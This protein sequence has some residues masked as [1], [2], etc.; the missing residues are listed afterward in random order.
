[1]FRINIKAF[2]A[3]F[4]L[5]LCFDAHTKSLF[6]EENFSALVADKRAALIGDTITIIILEN[7]QAK[8][9]SG[10]SNVNDIG[11]T[12]SGKSPQGSWPFGMAVGTEFSGDAV[13]SRNGFIKAQITAVVVAIDE[14]DNL[15]IKGNQNITID[16]ELQSIELSGHVRP[17]DIQAD[18]TLLSSR[19]MDAN[20]NFT[21]EKKPEGMI[22]LSLIHI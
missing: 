20:I 1:M 15:I 5:F 22:S 11:I 3:L 19:I 7:A 16:G 18:N 10:S 8:S 17:S 2:I 21:G 13:T 4:C 12:A 9:R 14:F 6:N